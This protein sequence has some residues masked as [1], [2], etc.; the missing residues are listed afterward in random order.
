MEWELRGILDLGVIFDQFSSLSQLYNALRTPGGGLHVVPTLIGCR[1][2]T[3]ACN[4]M[5][6]HVVPDSRRVR[7]RRRR[8]R[9]QQGSDA[10]IG[11]AICMPLPCVCAA[12]VCCVTV[13]CGVR[14]RAESSYDRPHHRRHRRCPQ[15]DVARRDGPGARFNGRTAAERWHRSH[16]L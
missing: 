12:W 16:P 11:W 2:V 1:L 13:V 3:G 7:A 5:Q 9:P 8:R 15:Q 10:V 4:P 6:S 14:L